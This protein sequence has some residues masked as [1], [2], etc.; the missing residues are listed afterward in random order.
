MRQTRRAH[1]VDAGQQRL[2]QLVDAQVAIREELRR[3]RQTR[4]QEE[5]LSRLRDRTPVWT[6]FDEHAG[7]AG[8]AGR[9]PTSR[10]R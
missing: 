4:A 9:S 1:G 6:M 5:Y 2:G 10:T 7:A 8:I 3:Q